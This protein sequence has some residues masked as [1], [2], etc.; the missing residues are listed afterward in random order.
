M[1]CFS[2]NN[3]IKNQETTETQCIKHARFLVS[4]QYIQCL[5]PLL[6][7][8][9]DHCM[10]ITVNDVYFLIKIINILVDNRLYRW[11]DN[12]KRF[13]L[14]LVSDLCTILCPMLQHASSEVALVLKNATHLLKTIPEV[15]G[16]ILHNG[17]DYVDPCYRFYSMLLRLILKDDTPKDITESETLM[18]LPIQDENELATDVNEKTYDATNV[19]PLDKDLILSYF[20]L[21]RKYY[22]PESIDQN[23]GNDK[24][25][26][27]LSNEWKKFDLLELKHDNEQ[28]RKENNLSKDEISRLH[29]KFKRTQAEC[30]R[31][32]TEMNRLTTMIEQLTA[33]STS[34]LQETIIQTSASSVSAGESHEENTV[35]QI[36]DIPPHAIAVERAEKFIRAISHRRSSCKNDD[37]RQSVR[38]SLQHLGSD[39]YTSPVHFL[40]ELIQVKPIFIIYSLKFI[41]CRML[42]TI[43]IL[44]K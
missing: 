24:A 36:E 14:I 40:Y 35:D 20:N 33:M 2:R 19:L 17:N 12:R 39:L 25:K 7:S 5:A 27:L 26:I 3:T 21:N 10:H 13:S 42:K 37:M 41:C 22:S 29:D 28:L 18:K 32:K 11:I 8:S 1:F 31:S 30:D 38:G 43:Y 15:I 6:Y 44:K 9:P 4:E 34:N 16:F 23:S